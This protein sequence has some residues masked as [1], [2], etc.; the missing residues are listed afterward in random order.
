MNVTPIPDDIRRYLIQ[1]VPSVPYIEAVLL[2]RGGRQVAWQPALLSQRL[3]LREE[4]VVRL[5]ARLQA[6]G[7]VAAQASEPLRYQY[8]PASVELE[9]LWDRL[10]VVYSHSLIEVSTL[11]HTKSASKAK[12]LADAFRWRKDM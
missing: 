12:M 5:L 11:I 4:E 10:A 6:D 9:Q 1:C 8:A 7:L 3:Y 2:M